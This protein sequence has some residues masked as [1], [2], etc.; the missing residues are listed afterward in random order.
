MHSFA[1][2]FVKVFIDNQLED[3]LKERD[4]ELAEFRRKKQREEAHLMT[5][6]EEIGNGQH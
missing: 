5:F 1:L 2:S 4:L 3:D 6:K